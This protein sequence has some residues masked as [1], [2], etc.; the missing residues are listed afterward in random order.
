MLEDNFVWFFLFEFVKIVDNL[1]VLYI[2]L[3]VKNML[4]YLFLIFVKMF[5]KFF[6]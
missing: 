5:F 3:A 6:L 2:F 1:I 4:L